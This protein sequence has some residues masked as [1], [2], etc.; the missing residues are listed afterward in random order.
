MGSRV[1]WRFVNAAVSGTSHV[2]AGLPCQ[3]DCLVDV[4]TLGEDEILIAIA[5]DGAGS[6]QRAEEGSGILCASLLASAMECLQ[7][8]ASIERLTRE[9]VEQWIGRARNEIETRARD[10]ALVPRDFA[11]TLV[12][13][14]AGAAAAAFFQ[15]GDGAVVIGAGESC[16]VV[17]WPDSGEYANMTF[18][19]TDDDWTKHLQFDVRR[20]RVDELA[21][22]TDGLQRLALQ[23][24]TRTPHAP[25]FA[26]MFATLRK[27]S[28]GFAA[29]LES[30]L[31]AFLS[32]SAVNDR[33]DDDKSLVIATR[34]AGA[35]DGAR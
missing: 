8:G 23:F 29:D 22:M 18:F 26:P 11:C 1:S 32:S 28:A 9:D 27:R 6:A 3:D 33:T 4:M 30:E 17:F 19:T 25:F 12:A 7:G 35:A 34:R 31:V 10:H 24:D 21:L 15:I 16:E 14:I 20:M 2:R 5:S 13:A